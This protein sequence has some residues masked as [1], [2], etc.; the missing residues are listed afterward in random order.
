MREHV[1]PGTFI[2]VIDAHNPKEQELDTGL[3]SSNKVVVDILEQ[4]ALISELH[5]RIEAE[6]IT[7]DDV[8]AE[9]RRIIVGHLPGRTSDEE[10]IIF[11]STGMALQDVAAAAIV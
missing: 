4:C 10:T 5:H 11:D 2:V 1:R 8:H 9:L 7:R 3:L 6:V